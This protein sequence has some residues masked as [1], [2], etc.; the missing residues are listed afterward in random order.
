M[1]VRLILISLANGSVLRNT[2]K[3]E[4]AEVSLYQY[5]RAG[6]QRRCRC[7]NTSEQRAMTECL[8]LVVQTSRMRMAAER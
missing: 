2:H 5:K 8:R 6:R 1:D 3:P 4:A 7:I